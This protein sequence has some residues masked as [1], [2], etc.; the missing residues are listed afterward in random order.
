MQSVD[1]I[2]AQDEKRDLL[3]SMLAANIAFQRKWKVISMGAYTLSTAGT[4]ICT[5]AATILAALQLGTE[6]AILSGVATIF[7]SLEKSLMF[8]DKWKVH[9]SV[10][11]KLESLRSEL[12]FGLV[13]T[14][15]AFRRLEK[16]LEDY[17]NEL[18]FV[19]KE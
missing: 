5:S 6:A 17:S 11:T 4:I 3:L 16:S 1:P 14:E 15:T 7:I 10:T 19:P 8:R 12:E 18:P 2:K 9:L 13:D